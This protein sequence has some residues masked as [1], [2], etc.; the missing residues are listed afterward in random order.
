MSP[1]KA[2]TKSA[3]AGSTDLVGQ[4]TWERCPRIHFPRA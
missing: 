3:S 1:T 2:A 4:T